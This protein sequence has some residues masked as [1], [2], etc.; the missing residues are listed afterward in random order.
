MSK[1]SRVTTNARAESAPLSNLDEYRYWVEVYKNRPQYITEDRHLMYLNNID[2][3]Y[4]LLSDEEK[5]IVLNEEITKGDHH[6][7]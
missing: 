4:R 7:G 5:E 2:T 6:D 1:S 3:A